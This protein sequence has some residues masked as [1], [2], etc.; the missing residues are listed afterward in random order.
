MILGLKFSLLVDLCFWAVTSTSVYQTFFF[1]FTP[2]VRQVGVS[3][4]GGSGARYEKSSS[5]L[6]DKAVKKGSPPIPCPEQVFV[7]KI[8]PSVFHNGYFLSPPF[9]ARRGSFLAL[10]LRNLAES[11]EMKPTKVYGSLPGY[12]PESFSLSRQCTASLG[13]VFHTIIS[14]VHGSSGVCSR[15][16]GLDH[17]NLPVFSDFRC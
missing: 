7:M 6:W 13:Q 8:G 4:G 17:R 3:V 10:H 15:E 1:S 11:L 5:P 9:G 12:T 16:A 14:Q 2:Y